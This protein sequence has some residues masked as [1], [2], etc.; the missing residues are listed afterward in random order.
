MIAS[1][2]RGATLQQVIHCLRYFL[3]LLCADKVQYLLRM[4][5]RMA[6]GPAYNCFWC[7][8]NMT[9]RVNG[10]FAGNRM[11]CLASGNIADFWRRPP[12]LMMFC[13]LMN[14]AKL[15]NLLLRD[16]RLFVF[17]TFKSCLNAIFWTIFIKR[18]LAFVNS[19]V[20]IRPV[21]LV[22]GLPL[23]FLIN[24]KHSAVIR[25]N[26]FNDENLVSRS[27]SFS[28]MAIALINCF[29]SGKS[30]DDSGNTRVPHLRFFPQPWWSIP[31]KSCI[32]QLWRKVSSWYII[33]WIMFSADMEPIICSRWSKNL[34]DSVSYKNVPFLIG[35]FY[36]M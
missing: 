32:D 14:G 3:T 18:R 12:T 25:I 10:W 4:A 7:S 30:F 1:E 27:C 15:I 16:T 28:V 23:L 5:A 2:I 24:L 29:C 26:L 31:P 9:R 6:C 20:N 22:A 11:G 8:Y 13:E 35:C 36:L 33:S 34:T 21:S 17:K 19:R